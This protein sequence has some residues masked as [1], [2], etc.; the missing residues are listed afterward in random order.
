MKTIYLPLLVL[1][2]L[3]IGF[4]V[5]V[6]Y[7]SSELPE[8]VATHFSFDGTPD[9]WMSR[10]KHLLFFA[11]FGIGI[12][13]FLACIGLVSRFIPTSFI[14]LPNRD[15]W[16]SPERK[17][18]TCLYMSRQMIWFGCIMVLFFAGIQYSIV[19]ANQS[20]PVKMPN[21]LFWFLFVG[22]LVAI[23]IWTI[24]LIQHFSKKHMMA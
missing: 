17:H 21:E 5:Y 4:L 9:G 7:S 10:D 18:Q 16:L 2:V 13:W 1:V 22:F 3:S 20:S 14:N 19:K 12:S 23:T 24:A 11:L 15:Y 6:Y 8:R